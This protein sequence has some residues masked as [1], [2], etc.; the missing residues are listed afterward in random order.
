MKLASGDPYWYSP[1]LERAALN[2]PAQPSGGLCCEEMGARPGWAALRWAVL[3]R[4]PQGARAARPRP[5][6]FSDASAVFGSSTSLTSSCL[7]VVLQAW[8]RLWRCWASSWPTPPRAPPRSS[9]R[10]TAR[11]SSRAGEGRGRPCWRIQYKD[12]R[13]LC[14]RLAAPFL[15]R[16]T[17]DPPL[18]PSGRRWWCARCRWWG[19]GWWR[20]RRSWAAPSPSTCTTARAASATPRSG[21]SAERGGA[22]CHAEIPPSDKA[23]RGGTHAETAC[24]E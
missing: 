5:L 2:V 23:E 20:P 15:W 6:C 17:P 18:A 7:C 10:R 4:R 3:P 9:P 1:V 8:A 13:V 11:A 12:S 14:V 19:S 22:C 16:L 21:C 24:Q